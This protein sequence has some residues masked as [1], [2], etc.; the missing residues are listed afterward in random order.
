MLIDANVPYKMRHKIMSEA[1]LTANKLDSLVVS[2]INEVMQTR[3]EHFG[4]KVQKF[5]KHMRTWGEAGV[6]KIKISTSLKLKD[7]GV[8]C[9]FS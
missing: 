6:V 8:I 1:N 9:L 7:K 5:E 2:E 3:Y 4:M